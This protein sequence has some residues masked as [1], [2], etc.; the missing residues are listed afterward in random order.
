QQA[1]IEMARDDAAEEKQFL[2]DIKA[3]KYRK[4]R[5]NRWRG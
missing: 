3:G 4:E 5:E 2:A 1:I